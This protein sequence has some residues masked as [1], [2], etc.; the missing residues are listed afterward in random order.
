MMA[1]SLPREIRANAV[2]LNKSKSLRLS[3]D[4][5]SYTLI[6]GRIKIILMSY[7]YFNSAKHRKDAKIYQGLMA[8]LA[9]LVVNVWYSFLM[10][11]QVII[12]NYFGGVLCLLV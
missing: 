2:Q 7:I 10:N 12:F 3:Q 8:E 11:F 4:F 6:L 1:P 5:N 9:N